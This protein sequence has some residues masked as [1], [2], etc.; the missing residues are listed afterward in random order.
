MEFRNTMFWGLDEVSL[1]VL[2]RFVAAGFDM[3]FPSQTV[4]VK[5]DA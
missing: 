4:Y 1:S 2:E 3:A 5:K